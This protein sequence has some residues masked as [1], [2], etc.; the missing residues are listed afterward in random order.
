MSDRS[1]TYVSYEASV[2]YIF[3]KLC[4]NGIYAT[5]VYFVEYTKYTNIQNE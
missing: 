2:N 5:I 4:K 1:H 3:C